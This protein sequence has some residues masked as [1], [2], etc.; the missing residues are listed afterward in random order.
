[1]LIVW[2]GV[3]K[4]PKSIK[5]LLRI[6]YNAVSRKA[7]KTDRPQGIIL[8]YFCSMNSKLMQTQN[9]K[10][11]M[12]GGGWM[13]GWMHTSK[14]DAVN[15]YGIFHPKAPNFFLSCT[16]ALKKHRPNNSFFQ[17]G[18]GP[19]S[20]QTASVTTPPTP[21]RERKRLALIPGGGSTVI[22]NDSK[23]S[24]LIKYSESKQSKTKKQNSV[25]SPW[26]LPAGW[27]LEMQDRVSNLTTCES[28][29]QLSF[30]D[31]IT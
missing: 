24:W 7:L 22:C 27:R 8:C 2:R 15:S 5:T 14:S 18:P 11:K 21:P 16:T 28:L 9:N 17:A 19:E 1:M 13:T 25:I 3:K 31:G 30:L 4:K 12:N 10:L 23:Q 26:V 20:S 29:D 6:H